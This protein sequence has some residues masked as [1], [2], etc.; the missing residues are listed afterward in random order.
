[1]VSAMVVGFL[2][3]VLR[4]DI[5]FCICG[6]GKGIISYQIQYTTPYLRWFETDM[7]LRSAWEWT[8]DYWQG[9]YYTVTNISILDWDISYIAWSAVALISAFFAFVFAMALVVVAVEALQLA[10][11]FKWIDKK[12]NY[13][14]YSWLEIFIIFLA[15]LLLLLLVAV[16]FGVLGYLLD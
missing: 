10:R 13:R 2:G 5:E 4:K 8:V 9:Y 14:E 15:T 3:D 1:M 16:L 7:T 11:A 12:L 6:H